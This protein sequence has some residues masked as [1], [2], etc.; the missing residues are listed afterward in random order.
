MS[1]PLPYDEIKF[2][3]NVKLQDFSNTPDDPDF[4]YFVEVG[5]IYPE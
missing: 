4:G 1:Q 5:L 2:F 3:K